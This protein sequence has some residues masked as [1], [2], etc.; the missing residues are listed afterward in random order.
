MAI[1][2][3]ASVVPLP[4]DTF[5]YTLTLPN[6]TGGVEDDRGFTN[7]SFSWVGPLR[8]NSPDNSSCPTVCGPDAGGS[9]KSS[10]L[11]AG[12]SFTASG[13]NPE[14]NVMFSD[15]SGPNFASSNTVTFTIIEPDAFWANI[16]GQTFD[17]ASFAIGGSDPA[18]RECTVFTTTT[19][20]TT[21]TPEPGYSI[22]IAML[23]AG[24]AAVALRRR[25]PA[26]GRQRC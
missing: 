16:G 21:T 11:F 19:T 24:V 12:F 5:T 25:L 13:S 23:M 26:F 22:L 20:T 7:Y 8:F 6:I 17:N 10:E 14:V 18:C 15:F 2:S 4:L 3:F 9:V 1:P